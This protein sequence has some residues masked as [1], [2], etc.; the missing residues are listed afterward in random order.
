METGWR[1]VEDNG[2]VSNVCS[3][4]DADTVTHGSSESFYGLETFRVIT[5]PICLALLIFRQMPGEELS[6]IEDQL[7]DV[8]RYFWD[9]WLRTRYVNM[10]ESKQVAF[11][12]DKF[13]TAENP[14]CAMDFQCNPQIISRNGFIFW[15]RSA[16]N[17]PVLDGNFVMDERY[18]SVQVPPAKIKNIAE[19]SPD[20]METATTR[21][22]Y[23][24]GNM[25]F[26]DEKIPLLDLV[27]ADSRVGRRMMQMERTQESACLPL[28]TYQGGALNLSLGISHVIRD[29]IG[30]RW[31]RYALKFYPD[32]AY[33]AT[34]ATFAPADPA[35]WSRF[36]RVFPFVQ[37]R[38]PNG[39][40]DYVENEY[41][42]RA[43]FGI[44]TFFTPMVMA[45]RSHPVAQS[46]GTAKVGDGNR[47]YGGEARWRNEYHRE[48]N[49]DREIGNWELNFGAGAEP[50]RPENGNAFFHR[51]AHGVMMAT[52]VCP[53]EMMGC[54]I[55]PMGTDCYQEVLP[56][57]T[58]IVAGV[59]RGANVVSQN[60]Y[61][62]E[63]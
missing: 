58:G 37:V 16:T 10:C 29:Y 9:D 11:V 3:R 7:H 6:H 13:F 23:S 59:S 43:P 2:C 31:D 55:V 27:V 39:T 49:P 33:N 5:D 63:F 53:P 52:S 12:E 32:D 28:F 24:E 35:T 34:V 61:K 30:I 60:N 56:G 1:I 48:C 46:L 44:S 25:P 62:F 18:V 38:L 15:N 51:L 50:I 41:Y 20:W 47:S 57:E 22:Q 45:M 40:L 21:L 36:K 42:A 54:S 26:A 19:L 14:Q 8:S 4:P 17:M